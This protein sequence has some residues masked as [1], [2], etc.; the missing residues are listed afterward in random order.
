M[1][2][3]AARRSPAPVDAPAPDAPSAPVEV[4]RH[5]VKGRGLFATRPIAAGEIIE[6]APVIVFPAADCALLDR[7]AIGHYYFDWTDGPAKGGAMPLGLLALC[8]HSPHP[9]ARVHQNHR[10]QTLEL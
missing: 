5:K 10:D 8:N 4:R 3:G 6:A 2:A 7:T 1:G 9:R